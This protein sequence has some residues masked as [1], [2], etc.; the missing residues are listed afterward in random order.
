V[1]HEQRG[2]GEM[3]GKSLKE[4]EKA[5]GITP[6]YSYFLDDVDMVRDQIASWYPGLPVFLYGFSMGGNV[7]ANYLLCRS[8]GR[9]EKVVLAAP[10]FRLYRPLHPVLRMMARGLGRISPRIRV[11]AKLRQHIPEDDLLFHDLLSLRLHAEITDAGE[12]AIS[13][14]GQIT[15]P[16]LVFCG[17][18]GR[19]VCSKAILD[20]ARNAKGNVTLRTVPDGGHRLHTDAAGAEVLREVLDFCR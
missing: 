14:A 19:L 4:R 18:A 12:F 11:S 3:P 17:G 15:V 10:W 6:G 16:V 1:V 5:R 2:F 8:Q 7:A 9:Y 20:F 13:H